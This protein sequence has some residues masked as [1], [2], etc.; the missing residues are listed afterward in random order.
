ML[1][2]PTGIEK[3]DNLLPGGWAVGRVNIVYGPPASLKTS[4]CIASSKLFSSRGGV[5]FYLDTESKITS[6]PKG[7]AYYECHEVNPFLEKLAEI[8]SRL[9]YLN[10]PLV[11][12]VV[13]SASAPFHLLYLENPGYARE[14]HAVFNHFIRSLTGQ[15][16]T[17]IITSWQLRGYFGQTLDPAAVLRTSRSGR[18][19][20][21]YL[22]KSMDTLVG[23]EVVMVEEVVNA[24]AL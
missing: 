2:I 22:E 12:V 19:L 11:L 17:V 15:G 14:K 13:D 23:K 1:R 4:I 24:A 16:A 20:T 5:V 21:I 3:L 9:R 7:V 18:Y 10:P 6:P 8:N